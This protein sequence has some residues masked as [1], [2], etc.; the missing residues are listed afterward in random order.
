[1]N[2]DLVLYDTPGSPCARRVRIVLLEK[3]LHWTDRSAIV[4]RSPRRR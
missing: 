3:G 4:K 1:M 2:Q